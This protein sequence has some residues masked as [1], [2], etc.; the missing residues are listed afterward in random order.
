LRPAIVAK[1]SSDLAGIRAA[2]AASEDVDRA[3]VKEVRDVAPA[4]K[5]NV[6][7]VVAKVNSAE[8]KANAGP[9]KAVKAASHVLISSQSRTSR[10]SSNP[11]VN[12]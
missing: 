10:Y 2:I 6:D 4:G 3:V 12:R 9:V 5:V 8:D 1:E 11:K 7:P